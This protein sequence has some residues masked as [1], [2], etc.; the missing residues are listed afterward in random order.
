MN[1]RVHSY[2]VGPK[3]GVSGDLNSGSSYGEQ[4]RWWTR[5]S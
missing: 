4:A 1:R 3:S 2:W 5:N